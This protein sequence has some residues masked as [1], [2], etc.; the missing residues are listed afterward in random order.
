V[1]ELVK[2]EIFGPVMECVWYISKGKQ[3]QLLALLPSF[4]TKEYT[5]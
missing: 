2:F 3:L 1:V 4:K 5:N